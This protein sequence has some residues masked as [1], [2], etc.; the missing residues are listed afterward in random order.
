MSHEAIAPS[1][2]IREYTRELH[3]NNAAVFAGAGLS[4]DSGY[5]DWKG[6]LCD[7]IEDLKLDPD[8]ETDLVTIAQFHCN[9]V[10]GKG[11]LTQ[12]IFDEFSKSRVPTENHR[13]LSRLPIQSYWTTNYDKLIETS[14]VDAKKV[15]DVKYT[16]K[17]LAVT[18]LDRDVVIYKMHG[19]IDHPAEAIIS[20]DDYEAYPYKM[21]AYVA[22]LRGDLIEKTFLFLGLS[23]TDPNLDF[24]LS[25]VR[26]LY[27]E[28]QR[29]HYSIQKRVSKRADESDKEFRYQELKQHY[30]VKDLKRF[31]IQTVLVDDYSDIT[32]LL[33]EV[34]IRFYRHSIFISGAAQD[35]GTWSQ[36]SAESFLH[37]LSY[38]LAKSGCRIVTGF[39]L[40]VGSPVIN[41]A[42]AWLNDEGKT[43]SDEDIVMRPFPQVATG[44]MNLP[45][46]W[47]TYREHMLSQAGIVVFVFGNKLDPSG[48]VISSNGMRQEFEIAIS[49]GLI[50]IPI[51]ATGF[52]AEE[53]WKEVSADLKK[54]IP[55]ADYAFESDFVRLGDTS[56]APN[57]L[58]SI[59]SK[60]IKYLQ[61]N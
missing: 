47:K 45:D 14:V 56:L 19:D 53:L 39:G 32:R 24:I 28:N 41:G 8:V 34:A 30:F 29:Q 21:S 59:V 51:G 55:T 11:A 42:L 7:F 54:F 2:F 60:L 17:H 27:E 38:T 25:R 1:T 10:G 4:M 52:L 13:I 20:K 26:V 50:P 23:F 9:Q 33:N 46:Q 5:V 12:R 58:L 49:A 18:R 40:G 43:I 36:N 31:G 57:D 16:M 48:K 6:L 22:A 35:F 37:R 15:P 3:N 44:G 61:K